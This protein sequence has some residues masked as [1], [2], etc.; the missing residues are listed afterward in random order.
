MRG[1]QSGRPESGDAPLNIG[2]ADE[3]DGLAV[4]LLSRGVK[5]KK[6]LQRIHRRSGGGV[7]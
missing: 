6:V 3:T 2:T 4:A 5:A 1:G 7:W